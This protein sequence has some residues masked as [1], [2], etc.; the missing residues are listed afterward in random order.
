MFKGPRAGR[1]R[2]D[3]VDSQLRIKVRG[4]VQAVRV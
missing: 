1:F 2:G 4:G 3:S